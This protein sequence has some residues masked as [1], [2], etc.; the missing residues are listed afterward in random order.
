M[1]Q[2]YFT[3]G[4]SDESKMEMFSC[5]RLLWESDIGEDVKQWT[6]ENWATW[7]EEKPEWFT[8][9]IVS[10]VPDEYI[11]TERLEAL[12][13]HRKRRGSAAGS[14]R[15]FLLLNARE[16]VEEGGGGSRKNITTK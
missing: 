14:M 11:P 13:A 10:M 12:G 15:E 16:E 2:E 9:Q 1:V 4:E 3:K 5:Q 6:T 7:V 8:P